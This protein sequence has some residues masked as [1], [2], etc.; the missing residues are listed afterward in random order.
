ML[1]PASQRQ[2]LCLWR[3][4][5]SLLQI[6]GGQQTKPG[7]PSVGVAQLSELHCRRALR[8]VDFGNGFRGSTPPQ[9]ATLLRSWSPGNRL[10]VTTRCRLQ[11]R[12]MYGQNSNR[13]RINDNI[14]GL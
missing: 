14:K 5:A 6:F 3:H 7:L 10:D 2:S 4:S 12:L 8:H 1:P 13:L 11:A 9:W